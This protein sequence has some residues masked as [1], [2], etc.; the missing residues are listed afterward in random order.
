MKKYTFLLMLLVFV[1]SFAQKKKITTS[2]SLTVLAKVDNLVAEISDGNF[3]ITK[4]EKGKAAESI[5]IKI[6]DKSFLALNCKLAM[7]NT[8]GSNLVVLS[9][10]EKSM[11]I[12]ASK[13]EDITTISAKI[14]DFPSKKEV[15]NNVKKSTKIT[16]KVFLDKNKTASE[17]QEKI[18]NEGFELILNPNGT[19]FQK[20]KSKEIKWVYDALAKEFKSQ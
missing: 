4:K 1:S 9:W 5:Q 14:F 13:T 12:T 20:I 10:E 11:L 18:R 2:K 6:G 16:E 15:F 7:F 8:A 3:Q 19:I 17:M